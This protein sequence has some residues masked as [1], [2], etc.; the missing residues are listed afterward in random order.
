[1]TEAEKEIVKQAR[2]AMA[3]MS[4]QVDQLVAKVRDGGEVTDEEWE[5]LRLMFFGKSKGD[6]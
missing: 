6:E 3:R 4:A 2:R 5:A 1:M